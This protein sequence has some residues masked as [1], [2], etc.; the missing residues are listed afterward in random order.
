MFK[1]YCFYIVSVRLEDE[2]DRGGAKVL[3]KEEI[4]S[5]GHVHDA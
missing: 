2:E 1:A 3:V 5:H 4:L